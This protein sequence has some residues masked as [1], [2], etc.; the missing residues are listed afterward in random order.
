MTSAIEYLLEGDIFPALS[1]PY[2]S[3]IGGWFYAILILAIASA[4]Q[5][6]TQSMEA[7]GIVLLTL[8]GAG[9][10]T[11]LIPGVTE[12]VNWNLSA[13]LSLIAIIGFTMMIWK[14]V[15]RYR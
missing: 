11:N 15:R 3:L 2:T 9:I 13:I 4:V 14:T 7:T 6:R 1:T 5:F 12:G 10:I 8:S